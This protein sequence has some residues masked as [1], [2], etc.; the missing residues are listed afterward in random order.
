MGA[1]APR[2]KGAVGEA[3]ATGIGRHYAGGVTVHAPATGPLVARTVAIDDPG[4]LLAALPVPGMSWVRKGEGMVAWGEVAR[5]DGAGPDRMVAAQVWWRQATRHATVRDEVQIPGTGL[6]AFGAFAF[7]DGSPAGGTLVVPQYVLGRRDGH[8]WF[9]AVAVGE[10]PDASP[11]MEEML[12]QAL[13]QRAP[14]TAHGAVTEAAVNREAWDQSV[15]AA[16]GLIREGALDKVVL[17]RAVDVEAEQPVDVRALLSALAADYPMCWAFHVDG[18]VGATPELLAR[19]DQGLVTSRVL[20]GTIRMTGDDAAD[21]ARAGALAR[22]SK[23]RE[24]H[25]YAARS[26]TQAL[27]AHCGSVNVPDEPFVLHLPNVMHLATDITGVLSHNVASLELVDELHPSAAVCGTPTLAAAAVIDRL[28][29]MDRGRYAG[30]VGWLDSSGDGEWG[31]ALRS[32]EMSATDPSRLRL[33]AGCGIVAASAPGAEWAESEAKLEPMRR[34]LGVEAPVEEDPADADKSPVEESAAVEG[35]VGDVGDSPI[36]EV[37]AVEP[38][39]PEPDVDSEPEPTPEP[40]PT[41][42]PEPRLVPAP[43]PLS[44]P[45]PEPVLHPAPETDP[46]PEPEPSPATEPISEPEPAPSAPH[47]TSTDRPAFA[48]FELGGEADFPTLRVRDEPLG[49]IPSFARNGREQ[50]PTGSLSWDTADWEERYASRDAV[51]SAQPNAQLVEEAQSLAPGRAFDAGCGEGA[52]AVW[53]AARGWQVTAVDV[54]PTAI[55]RAREAAVRESVAGKVDW[56][57]GDAT[58]RSQD[59]ATY[60]LVTSHFAH[61]QAGIV[62]LVRTLARLVV[63]G[64]VLLIVGHDPRDPHTIDHPRLSSTAFRAEDAALGLDPDA[65]SIEFADVR[66]RGIEAHG[67]IV[68]RMDAVLRARRLS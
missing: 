51:W 23:D 14:V 16:V 37:A 41:A 32:A 2:T 11:D 52:D 68:T 18:L 12:A 21:L 13:A 36:E 1:R 50:Q 67:E 63:P 20:A 15:D 8:A 22:S 42:E 59:G 55:R 31:L 24:E 7:A 9:T 39:A 49:T 6:V 43:T 19:V 35:L 28:E 65:W 61:P 62:P 38:L 54:S 64:G 57:V 5:F 66:R 46:T 27:A 33:Y 48:E 44:E 45:E 30:P 58:A 29:S 34:A 17:A 47:V 3:A 26:V 40:A 56:R 53:L 10:F 25:E 4:D 60:D